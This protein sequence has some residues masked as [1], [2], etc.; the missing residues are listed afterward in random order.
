MLRARPLCSPVKDS[1]GCACIGSCQ[2]SLSRSI[3][4]CL[5]VCVHACV[6]MCMCV[7]VQVREYVCFCCARSVH[8]HVCVMP[9]CPAPPKQL[10]PS[11]QQ[12]VFMCANLARTLKQPLSVPMELSKIVIQPHISQA[13][14]RFSLPTSHTAHP[15]SSHLCDPHSKSS[16]RI[17]LQSYL[18][19]APSL[20]LTSGAGLCL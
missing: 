4:V 7:C 1:C 3:P 12:T 8:V 20:S 11:G 5:C 9:P 16:P 18:L 15:T 2:V 6:C 10:Q 19:P 13:P 14:P 17:A